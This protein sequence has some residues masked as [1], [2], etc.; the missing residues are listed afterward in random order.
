MQ[1]YSITTGHSIKKDY[2]MQYPAAGQ[3]ILEHSMATGT[4]QA[5]IVI[6][7]THI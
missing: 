6:I 5:L 2:N 4:T 7:R 1:E 3:N